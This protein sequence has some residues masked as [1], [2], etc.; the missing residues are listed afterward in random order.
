MSAALYYGDSAQRVIARLQKE[1]D[2]ARDAL[3]R[4]SVTA[5]Q[6]GAPHVDGGDAMQVDGQ[7][8]S[9]ET[10]AKIDETQQKLSAT[11]RKRPV[12]EDWATGDAIATYDVKSTVD[13]QFTGAKSLA[14]DETGD[15]FL[16][17]KFTT[18]STFCRAT[19]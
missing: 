9:K 10:M 1:R 6:N 2:E 15:F 18:S 3:S 12:P 4:V 5:V 7:G 13:T 17:G 14:V 11:R 19:S 16:C 8:L